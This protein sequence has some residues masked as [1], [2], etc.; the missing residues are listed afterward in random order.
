MLRGVGRHMAATNKII[1]DK[2]QSGRKPFLITV[3]MRR[4]Q[5]ALA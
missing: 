3:P 5:R 1:V 2:A 4:S